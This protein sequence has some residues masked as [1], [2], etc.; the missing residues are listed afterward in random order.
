MYPW[1]LATCAT[2]IALIG[3]VLPLVSQVSLVITDTTYCSDCIVLSEITKYSDT[4]NTLKGLGPPLETIG[5]S[6]GNVFYVTTD[7]DV[8]WFNPEKQ[9]GGNLELPARTGGSRSTRTARTA[10][11]TVYT[12]TPTDSLRHAWTTNGEYIESTRSLGVF[13]HSSHVVTPGEIVIASTLQSPRTVG[14]PLHRFTEGGEW[15]ES[16]GAESP[17][18]SAF[19]MRRLSRHLLSSRPSTF[20]TVTKYDYTIENITNAGRLLTTSQRRAEWFNSEEDIV[21]PN[22]ESPFSPWVQ[23]AIMDNN[24]HIVTIVLI[25]GARW[26]RGFGVPEEPS[27]APGRWITPIVDYATVFDSVV[28]VIDPTTNR[29]IASQR[30]DEYFVG[31]AGH[32]RIVAYGE[33]DNVGQFTLLEMEVQQ[34]STEQQ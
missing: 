30:F 2:G 10:N 27:N 34:I 1:G 17:V 6:N 33:D 8:A 16:F 5:A 20:W 14:Y 21:M 25:P 18:T 11:D 26:Q 12:Y 3:T 7:L 28:E 29:L 15:L 4:S 13:F 31:F 23:A 32:G 19:E 9:L 24:G 22:P